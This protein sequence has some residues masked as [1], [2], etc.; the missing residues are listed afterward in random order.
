MACISLTT[1]AGQAR[2]WA[3]T[4]FA[5]TDGRCG[6]ALAAQGWLFGVLDDGPIG[7]NLPL[8][9]GKNWFPAEPSVKGA[10]LPLH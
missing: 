8:T 3:N 7:R 6:I 9:R 4:S 10:A 5:P 1:G 2:A